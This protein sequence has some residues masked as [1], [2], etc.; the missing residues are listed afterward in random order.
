M[1][2]V[3]APMLLCHAVAAIITLV[4]DR[5]RNSSARITFLFRTNFRKLQP[6]RSLGPKVGACG[7]TDVT[8]SQRF[9]GTPLCGFQPFVTKIHRNARI[10]WLLVSQRARF[11]R[12]EK[13]FRSLC[14]RW[15]DHAL[16]IFLQK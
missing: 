9:N 15:D 13:A 3:G 11:E 10:F 5:R 6:S 7:N 12:F 14:R 8:H 2:L 4:S 16:S 1:G